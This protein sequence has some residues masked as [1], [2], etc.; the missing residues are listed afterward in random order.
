MFH[1]VLPFRVWYHFWSCIRS[2]FNTKICKFYTKLQIQTVKVE[3]YIFFEKIFNVRNTIPILINSTV[4]FVPEVTLFVHLSCSKDNDR[5]YSQKNFGMLQYEE[6]TSAFSLFKHYLDIIG[7]IA[8][9]HCD[10]YLLP[11]ISNNVCS[12]N[13]LRKI[14]RVVYISAIKLTRRLVITTCQDANSHAFIKCYNKYLNGVHYHNPYFS[15][16]R[17]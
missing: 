1:S 10:K 6:I 3:R 16:D 8:L 12:R 2:Q 4:V 17:S 5:P 7:R 13:V 11:L 9:N 14:K 15:I